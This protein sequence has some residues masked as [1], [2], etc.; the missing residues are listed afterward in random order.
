[1]KTSSRRPSECASSVAPEPVRRKKSRVSY[2]ERHLVDIHIVVIAFLRV[3]FVVP[4]NIAYT[5]TGVFLLG[6]KSTMYEM[7]H[8]LGWNLWLAPESYSKMKN[9]YF[10]DLPRDHAVV[11]S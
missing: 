9:D 6:G 1:M 11:P 8:A 10:A 4:G 3:D 2:D 5:R 7:K